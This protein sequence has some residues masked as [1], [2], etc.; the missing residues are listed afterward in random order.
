M[1]GGNYRI[2]GSDYRLVEMPRHA[3]RGYEIPDQVIEPGTSPRDGADGTPRKGVGI[4]IEPCEAKESFHGF[5]GSSPALRK[6]LKQIELVA[7]AEANV[8][9]LGESGTGKEL[10]ACA[11]HERS[12]RRAKGLIKINC[13]AIPRE[14]F[15]SEFFGHAKGAFSGAVRDRIGRFELADRGTLLLDEIGEIP[16]VLQ[17]KL[18]RVVQ[19]GE[20]ERVGEE[21][22]RVINVRIIAATNRN[23]GEEVAAGRFRQDLY[24]RLSVFPIE[25]PTLRSRP[26][27][28]PI[29]AE[30]FVKQSAARNNCP[31]PRLTQ[32]NLLK[33]A[34]HHWPGNIRELQN[35]IERAVI[36]SQ[37]GL[38]DFQFDQCS[39]APQNASTLAVSTQ[40]QWLESQRKSIVEALEKSSGRIYGQQGAAARLG[41]PPTT[42]SS[43]MASL[44]IA[45]RRVR[46]N[47]EQTGDAL[48]RPN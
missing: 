9:I 3:L 27:D 31:V 28:I 29:L 34:S 37:G 30:Y 25:T 47:S 35:V 39:P 6:V 13:A 19:E 5:V 10:V 8:L 2:F 7:P 32:S 12:Q 38:L 17:A 48:A 16:L 22:T 33:L 4:P 21:K 26:E 11:I 45:R 24:F 46:K 1:S 36:V 20:F 42:L 23:L 14:L 15:E 18:L 40:R 43:R 44:G 41:L